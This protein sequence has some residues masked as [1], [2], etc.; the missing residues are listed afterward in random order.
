M[1]MVQGSSLIFIRDKNGMELAI[2]KM[3]G[4]VKPYHFSGITEAQA[5]NSDGWI[6]SEKYK[7]PYYD[8]IANTF[9]YR[10]YNTDTGE[11]AYLIVEL[12]WFTSFC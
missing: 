12:N 11:Q 2:N 8:A 10:L 3:G 5:F 1:N 4:N 7:S 9:R 6:F